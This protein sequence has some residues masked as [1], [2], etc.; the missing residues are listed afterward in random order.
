MKK[1]LILLSVLLML[2]FSACA[3]SSTSYH[4]EVNG[5]LYT[6]D[7]ENKTISDAENTYHYSIAGR[8]IDI[9]YPDG[10]S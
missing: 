8:E 2:L 1:A 10:S 3:E 9:I 6:V 7:T 5:T 4:V